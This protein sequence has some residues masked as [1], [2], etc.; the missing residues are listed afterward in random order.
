[1][2]EQIKVNELSAKMFGG[3]LKANGTFAR[4]AAGVHEIVVIQ[5]FSLET[6]YTHRW[7]AERPSVD[8]GFVEALT[9][10]IVSSLRTSPKA[11][12]YVQGF[13]RCSLYIK[14]VI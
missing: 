6:P 10:F 14:G 8:E 12:W 1:M 3:D 5:P 9:A 2:K 7:C 13:H 4:T 11:R